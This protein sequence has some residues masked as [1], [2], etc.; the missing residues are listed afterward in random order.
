MKQIK[1]IIFD[2]GSVLLDIDVE[3]TLQAFE[4]LGIPKE[5]LQDIYQQPENFFLLFEKGEISADEFRDRFRD[6]SNNHLTDSQIDLAW[7]AMVVGFQD[8]IIQLMKYLVIKYRLY[9][10]SNTNEIH[11]P[12]YTNQFKKSSGGVTFEDIFTKIYYSHVLRLSKPDP[13]IYTHVL[14]D[15]GIDPEE[16]IFIDDLFQNVV[17]SNE[18]GL[19]ACQ[20]KEEIRLKDLLKQ[21]KIT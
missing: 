13:Q 8:D 6:L 3:K 2:L 9:L 10:L 18:T 14:K 1:N 7:S 4:K 11:V 19:P 12:V 21:H 5:K 17:A 20:L 16:S 15:S